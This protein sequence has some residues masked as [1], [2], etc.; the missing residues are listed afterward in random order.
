[1]KIYNTLTRQKENFIPIEEGKVRFY[2]CGP[3]VYWTQ[4]IGNMRAMTMADLIRRSLSV[5]GYEV[6]FV[7]NYTDVGH[8]TG[9]NLGNADTGEDRMEKGA[10]REGLSPSE[11]ADKYIKIFEDD[12]QAL[13]ILPPTHQIRATEY[14]PQIIEM[15]DSLIEKSF[16]YVTPR[17]VYFDIT[18]A[19]DYNR[20]N[21]QNLEEN[22]HSAGV[23]DVT[24]SD[25]RNPQDFALWFFRT[26]SHK[27]ALQYWPSPFRSTDVEN[28]EGFPGWHIECSAMIKAMLGVTIDIHMGGVEHIAVHHTNEIAQSEGANG[29]EFVHYW[30]HNEHLNVNNEKMSKS[31]GTGYSLSEI[32]DK[33]Y[34]PMIL[35]YFFLQA[36]YRSTQN[37]TFEALDAAQTALNRLRSQLSTFNSQSDRT[38]L[39]DEKK[40]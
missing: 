29:V 34:D 12:T 2:Q 8:L 26:G 16:A 36:H 22:R 23:G 25:K 24:D 37:F 18:R 39:S 9:D 32:T 28:G 6:N 1:M 10:K 4:H 13:N 31:E 5:N 14:I 19:S 21:K 15:V 17:A 7:R 11:I 38:Q 30:I 27:N 33:G 20:L 40:S 35:R 3:T